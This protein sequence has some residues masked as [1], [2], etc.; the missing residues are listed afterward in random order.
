MRI[1]T[2]FATERDVDRA[3]SYASRRTGGSVGVLRRFTATSR[4]HARSFELV[5]SGNAR[6]M[7]RVDRTVHAA[8]WEQ[9]G[10]VLSFLYDVDPD[11]R[12]GSPPNGGYAGFDDF[13]KK[14]RH[15]F[16]LDTDYVR[17]TCPRCDGAGRYRES[18]DMF[19]RS[20]PVVTCP[21]CN[22]IGEVS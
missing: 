20:A 5:L 6:G 10:H 15:A 21:R 3:I 16:P 1:H 8:S 11:I 7:S 22:G 2:H 19:D 14:T 4:T 18:A 9:W 13:H 17:H 12:V